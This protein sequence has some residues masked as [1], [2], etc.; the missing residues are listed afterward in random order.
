M[1]NNSGGVVA[2]KLQFFET[3]DQARAAIPKNHSVVIRHGHN[4]EGSGLTFY[5]RP[6]SLADPN[7]R[8][9]LK[10]LCAGAKYFDQAAVI[11][12]ALT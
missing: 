1:K 9:K 7:Y 3:M 2:V 4:G 12:H 6:I 10:K 8:E 5:G 11:I